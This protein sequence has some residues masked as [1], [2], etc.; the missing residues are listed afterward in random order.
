MM[1]TAHYAAQRLRQRG[2]KVGVVNLRCFRPFP[3]EELRR[4]V[5]AAR[6]VLVLDRDIG[7]GT[8]GMVY[9]DITRALYH[10][11]NRPTALNFIIGTGGKDITPET[12]DRCV[13]LG[14]QEHAGKT[15]FWP[16]ARGSE[17]GIPYSQ[18][19]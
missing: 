18:G 11:D 3:E 14:K 5:G 1:R 4:A 8:S 7:Y 13:E 17:E 19:P 2:E 10:T 9:P 6:S 16:D 12:I 15:V